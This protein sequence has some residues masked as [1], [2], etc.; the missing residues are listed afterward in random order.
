MLLK[1]K[2]DFSKLKLGQQIYIVNLR[3]RK[4]YFAGFSPVGDTYVMLVDGANVSDMTTLYISTK[5]SSV[6][7]TVV[8]DYNEGKKIML[9]NLNKN[10][11]SI[12]KIYFEKWTEVE[13]RDFNIENLLSGD[14]I[15]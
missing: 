12:K 8:D 1:T 13:W 6:G 7:E 4:F 9:I 3:I 2:E 11:E 5:T 14:N 10:L 15:K